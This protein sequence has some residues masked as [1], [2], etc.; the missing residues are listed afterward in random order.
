MKAGWHVVRFWETDILSN[1]QEAASS[2][3]AIVSRRLLERILP[4]GSARGIAARNMPLP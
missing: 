4:H 3:H 1:P 2:I